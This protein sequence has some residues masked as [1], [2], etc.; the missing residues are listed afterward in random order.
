LSALPNQLGSDSPAQ[1]VT[2]ALLR[3]GPLSIADLVRELGVTTTAIRMQ[4]NR[5]VAKGWLVQTRRSAGPGR[6]AGVYALSE[7]ARREIGVRSG[8]ELSRLLLAEIAEQEGEQKTRSLLAGVSRRLA[9]AAKQSVGSGSPE[10]RLHRLAEFLSGEGIPAEAEAP[11]EGA[12]LTVFACPYATLS[13][14]Q[15]D[16]CE[17]ERAAFSEVVNS[18]VETHRCVLDGDAACEF[19]VRHTGQEGAQR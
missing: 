9:Q 1:R 3:H 12:R 19:H 13:A 6:P 5:L 10:E 15:K 18:P 14:P 4:V 7:R 2:A 8:P 11:P 16:L 17:L